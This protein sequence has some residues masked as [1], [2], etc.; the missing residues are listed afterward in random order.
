MKKLQ[1]FLDSIFTNQYLILDEWD[2]MDPEYDVYGI[3]E[4]PKNQR[5]LGIPESTRI[6][7]SYSP[8]FVIFKNDGK[9]M[10]QYS[11]TI[12]GTYLDPP[13]THYQESA[14]TFSSPERALV[15][16]IKFVIDEYAVNLFLE[17]DYTQE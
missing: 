1:K 8:D 10:F 2:E 6:L 13:D 15:G 7:K 3:Y 9:Y 17:P 11:V 14:E 12:S 5:A 4:I 16:I